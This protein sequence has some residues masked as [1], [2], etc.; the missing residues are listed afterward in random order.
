M[1][2][3]IAI[4][5][6]ALSLA[7]NA[8]IT[9]I[10]LTGRTT[11]GISS[12]AYITVQI[13]NGNLTIPGICT[14]VGGFSI[15]FTNM[16][17]SATNPANINIGDTIPAAFTKDNGNFA[18]LSLFTNNVTTNGAANG[19]IPMATNSG[20]AGGY[21][22]VPIAIGGGGGGTNFMATTNGTA[23]NATLNGTTIFANTNAFV[24]YTNTGIIPTMTGYTT[25]SGVA[26][27]SDENSSGTNEAWLA[28]GNYAAGQN[29]VGWVS[30]PSSGTHWIQYQFASPVTVAS[31]FQI[32]Q[33]AGA[34]YFFPSGQ[35][36]NGVVYLE[37]STDGSTWTTI[38]SNGVA[39]GGL[40]F[41]QFTNPITPVT[42]VNY[43]RERTVTT[44][45]APVA[46]HFQVYNLP[47]TEFESGGYVDVVAA[48][49]LF[50]NGVSLLGTVLQEI[51]GYAICNTNG[52]GTGTTLTN[53]NYVDTTNLYAQAAAIDTANDFTNIYGGKV[54]QFGQAVQDNN[55]TCSNRFDAY[56]PSGVAL[57]YECVSMGPNS[58]TIG[59]SCVS[60]GR[61]S[62]ALGQGS[63][64]TGNFSFA[65]GNGSQATNDFSFVWSDGGP[66][67]SYQQGCASN[68]TFNVWA[69][70]GVYLYGSGLYLN[71][72]P[73]VTT[74]ANT[75]YSGYQV[76]A[77]GGF[78]GIYTNMAVGILTNST[79]TDGEICTAVEL[80]NWGWTGSLTGYYLLQ[81]VT[82][83]MSGQ[84]VYNCP[85]LTGNYTVVQNGSSYLP[86]VTAWSPSIT[87]GF[88]IYERSTTTTITNT[89]TTGTW[90]L[91]L[92][93]TTTALGLPSFQIQRPGILTN[94]LCPLNFL[95]T[96]SAT[97]WYSFDVQPNTINAVVDK[98]GGGASVTVLESHINTKQ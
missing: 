83:P 22:W 95:T 84:A 35:T 29:F 27:A 90:E 88:G 47:H 64:A 53:A 69:V 13:T 43:V 24:A 18:T 71:G 94:Q 26:S 20:V 19:Y 66:G 91:T 58:V 52:F 67:G 56:T 92:K 77:A 57:G 49:G 11:N 89:S 82:S 33:L 55:S 78:N 38:C 7:A 73:V 79:G 81:D 70:N 86:S 41:L 39:P 5:F 72:Q 12:A 4:L 46:G 76:S 48:N 3:K 62:F 6:I 10:V 45:P 80:Q 37:A 93:L 32:G 61:D 23:L 31:A 85:T 65:V 54:S 51:I 17:Y 98:S 60:S 30:Q 42:N 8:Q 59:D 1:K 36:N 25:P 40:W 15:S 75:I 21:I 68:N 74:P 63:F 2:N 50:V 34:L 28:F 97:N 96:S 87:N 9:P 16:P 44:G 14:N